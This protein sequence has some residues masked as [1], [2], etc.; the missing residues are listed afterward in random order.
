M[1]SDT[2]SKEL[3]G[4]GYGLYHAILGITLLP[5]SIIAGLLY[6]HVNSNAP[7]YFGSLMALIASLLMIIFVIVDKNKQ[8]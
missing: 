6:D 4:T 2:V 3:R 7:F 8:K 1:I 5:A